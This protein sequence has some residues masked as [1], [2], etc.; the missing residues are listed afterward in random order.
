MEGR[1]DGLW[2]SSSTIQTE[3]N[4]SL[5]PET[6]GTPY[7][8]FCLIF[9]FICFVFYNLYFLSLFLFIGLYLHMTSFISYL[10]FGNELVNH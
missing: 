9:V 10:P 2:H 8:L 4:P 3:P 7:C 5:V 1:E 6:V